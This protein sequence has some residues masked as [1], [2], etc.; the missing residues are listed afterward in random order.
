MSWEA[1]KGRRYYYRAFR[2]QGRLVKQYVGS[3]SDAV[4]VAEQ[5]VALR[6]EQAARRQAEQERRQ[7]D[8]A[9]SDQVASLAAE[10]G[11]LMEAALL[12]AGYHRPQRK[13]WRKRRS[14]RTGDGDAARQSRVRGG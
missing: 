6:A 8:L 11:A 2:Q 10:A 12:A 4:A 3:G 7:L 13:P 14:R 9:L 1:R 5:D